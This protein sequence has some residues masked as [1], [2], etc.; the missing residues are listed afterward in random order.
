[1]CMRKKIQRCGIIVLTSYQLELRINLSQ[2]VKEDVCNVQW[3]QL[4]HVTKDIRVV[5]FAL[6]F[7]ASEN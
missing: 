2:T 6:S 7:S 1:M 3:T 4:V 5:S